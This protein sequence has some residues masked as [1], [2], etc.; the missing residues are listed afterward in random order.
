MD[1]YGPEKEINLCTMNGR[2]LWRDQFRC[3][4]SNFT[5]S[6][7]SKYIFA[8][9]PFEDNEDGNIEGKIFEL[10]YVVNEEE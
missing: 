8:L 5:V 7:R 1:Y 10:K 4:E 9:S 6:K 2:I 3:Q